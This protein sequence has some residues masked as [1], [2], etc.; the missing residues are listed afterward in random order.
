MYV[1]KA[2]LLASA[3]AATGWNV[4]GAHSAAQF[5]V[6]HM[7]VSTVRGAFETM[8]GTVSYDPAAPDK[9]SVKVE[10]DTASVNT[11]NSQRDDHLRSADFFDVAHYPKMTFVSTRVEKVADGQLKLTG[12]LTLHG[13]TRE[14]T[15]DVE[16][17]APPIQTDRG[18]RTGAAATTRINRKDFGLTWHQALEA[19][20]VMVSD[21]VTLTIDVELVEN[22]G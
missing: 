16:G 19:G 3:A 1:D 17:P 4:D 12:N 7:M 9:A 2:A 21:E 22:T 11:R 20:G 6:R 13:V 5:S 10:V 8:S 18:M 14:V 15:F